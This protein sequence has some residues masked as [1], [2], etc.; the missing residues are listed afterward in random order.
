MQRTIVNDLKYRF[1]RI[2]RAAN[3]SSRSLHGFHA[4]QIVYV[5]LP[6]LDKLFST[7]DHIFCVRNLS[8]QLLGKRSLGVDDALLS[9][10]DLF[11][12]SFKVILRHLCFFLRIQALLQ[13]QTCAKQCKDKCDTDNWLDR[14]KQD[15]K[16]IR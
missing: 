10:F 9:L 7:L 14:L 8:L 2:S 3:N 15:R 13:A 12:V 1:N 6:S 4:W 11:F 16:H 5:F